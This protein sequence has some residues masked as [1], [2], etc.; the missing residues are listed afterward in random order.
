M[1]SINKYVSNQSINEISFTNAIPI[2]KTKINSCHDVNDAFGEHN[3]FLIP[4][5]NIHEGFHDENKTPTQV[6]LSVVSKG[7][8]N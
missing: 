7:R 2:I 8:I 3:G 1:N 6:Y 4:I 5:Y